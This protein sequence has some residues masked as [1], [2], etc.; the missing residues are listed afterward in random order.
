MM[1]PSTVCACSLSARRCYQFHDENNK[2]RILV[3][4]LVDPGAH[5]GQ[6]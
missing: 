1:I 3:G 4:K 6:A 2:E 5:C